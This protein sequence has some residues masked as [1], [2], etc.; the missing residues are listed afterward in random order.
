M[1]FYLKSPSGHGL[2]TA[3][4]VGLAYDGI[5]IGWKQGAEVWPRDVYLLEINLMKLAH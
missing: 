5:T 2:S 4:L 3:M 1:N